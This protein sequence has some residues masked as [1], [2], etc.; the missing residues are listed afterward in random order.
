MTVARAGYAPETRAIDVAS[1]SKSFL[2]IQ[3]AQLTA[4]AA[5]TSQ[6]AA[7]RFSSTAKTRESH[8]GADLR[9][10]AGFAHFPDQEAGLSW[11]KLPAPACKQDRYSISRPPQG[12]G[13]RP[14]TSRLGGKFKKLFGGGDTAGMGCGQQSRRSPR[15]RRLQSITASSTNFL[16]LIFI[17]VREL[18]WLT[19]PRQDTS[20]STSA[21]S[22]EGSQSVDRRE[23]GAR[24]REQ[25]CRQS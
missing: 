22:A 3:L 16:R 15:E 13:L 18:T 4:G 24:V 5:I 23:S 11:R 9:G 1:G 2:V 20:R 12:S 21:R 8:S 10:Q 6:P 25:V 7:R 19:S 14:M 17:S